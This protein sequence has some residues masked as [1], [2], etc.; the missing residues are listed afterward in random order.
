MAIPF[1]D[2][3]MEKAWRENLS[4]S[5]STQR[6]NAHRLLLFYAVECGLKA[7][8]MRRQKKIRS[9]LCAEIAQYQ[10]DVNKLLE[11]LSAKPELKLPEQI[12]MKP[13]K[14]GNGYDE[15]KF[16]PGD[17]NQMWRYGGSCSLKDV[18]DQYI[19]S[20]LLEIVEWIKIELGPV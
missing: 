11:C 19:E 13:I 4:A 20:K 15:R 9:D 16:T 18:T 1:T 2:R 10:H 3:E 17:I 12:S 5:H 6:T 8:L 7:V 14:T